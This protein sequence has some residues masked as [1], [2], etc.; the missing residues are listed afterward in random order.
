MLKTIDTI[1]I[2]VLFVKTV[3]INKRKIMPIKVAIDD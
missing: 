2:W 3:L 1:R